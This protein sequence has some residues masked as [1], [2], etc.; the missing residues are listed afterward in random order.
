ME[1]VPAVIETDMYHYIRGIVREDLEDM[2]NNG[3][4]TA[5]ALRE[6]TAENAHLWSKVNYSANHEIADLWPGE[7]APSDAIYALGVD[8]EDDGAT[9]FVR[10][11]E[12]DSI[13]IIPESLTG[14]LP[15]LR[16]ITIEEATI[17]GY[18]WS[19]NIR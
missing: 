11:E 9:H 13:F 7:Y 1:E 4:T 18:N 6:K 17:E 2:L 3:L 8:S 5:Y 19:R 12:V 16:A 15:N 10:G 14:T